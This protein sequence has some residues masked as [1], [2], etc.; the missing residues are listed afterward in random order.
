MKV[1]DFVF[2]SERHSEIVARLRRDG[3]IKVKE[4]SEAFE[5]SEDLI[6][7]D[8]K[9]LELQGKC[10]R[11]Y[12]GAILIP[13][14]L[15]HSV[16]ARKNVDLES[17]NIIAKKIYDV[18]EDG[19][20]IF[21]DNSTTNLQVAHLLANGNKQCIVISNMIEILQ[22][23]AKNKNITTIGT[24][25][26][27]NLELNGFIGAITLSMVSR[28]NFDRCFIGTTGIDYKTM[29]MTTFDMDDGL[30]KDMALQNAKH[31]YLIMES[32][33][34]DLCGTYKFGNIK[35]IDCIITNSLP[36]GKIRN[37][38]KKHNINMM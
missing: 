26:N 31:T 28:H 23:L 17:K 6:R 20:T 24:G 13:T 35:K 11:V 16:Y 34:F 3:K 19:E 33:K 7:K 36:T 27:V 10:K 22:I 14:G 9:Q 29:E 25:G 37:I 21:L 38:F 4:L 12:G 32:K 2:T 8:L 5:V 1:S 18:I 15:E 30:I